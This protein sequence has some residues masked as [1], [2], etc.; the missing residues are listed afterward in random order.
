MSNIEIYS[1]FFDSANILQVEA[2]T[3]CPQGGDTGHGGRTLLRLSDQGGTNIRIKVDGQEV[4]INDSIEIVLGGDTE[5][6]TFVQSLEFA[7]KVY[8]EQY[9]R[10]KSQKTNENVE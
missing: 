6:Y 3:N 9:H 8:K 5:H 1:K 4:K 10:N 7:L 2:G